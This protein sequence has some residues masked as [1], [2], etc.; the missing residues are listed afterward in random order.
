VQLE[1]Q[2]RGTLLSVINDYYKVLPL[3]A[4]SHCTGVVTLESL[5]MD[6]H[7]LEVGY[8]GFIINACAGA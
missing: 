4:L 6:Q 1:S 2:Q 7:Y 3:V 5:R 8:I